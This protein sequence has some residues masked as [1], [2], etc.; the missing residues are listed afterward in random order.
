MF[1]GQNVGGAY[2]GIRFTFLPTEGREGVGYLTIWDISQ[3][4]NDAKN[5][6]T[7]FLCDHCVACTTINYAIQFLSIL[8]IYVS[9]DPVTIILAFNN[10]IVNSTAGTSAVSAHPSFE[11]VFSWW[12]WREKNEERNFLVTSISS[13]QKS[14]NLVH[15]LP[16]LDWLFLCSMS[17]CTSASRNSA[18]IL[19]Y[20]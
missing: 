19:T 12:K 15:V 10:A 6:R 9:T 11:L 20:P 18:K 14:C 4:E 13:I 7:F 3:M 5:E 2:S 1:C 16:I 8:S 17:P